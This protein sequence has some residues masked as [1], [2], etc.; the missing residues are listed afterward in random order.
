MNI[1]I[2]IGITLGIILLLVAALVVGFLAFIGY[3]FLK[4]V[5]ERGWG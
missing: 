3:Q 1:L 2:I 5:N 4:A